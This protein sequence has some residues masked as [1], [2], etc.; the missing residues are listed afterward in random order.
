[1][2]LGAASATIHLNVPALLLDESSTL[3]AAVRHA[4][5]R[6]RFIRTSLRR[7]FDARHAAMPS[8]TREMPQAVAMYDDQAL[9]T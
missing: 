8:A 3:Q 9:G 5:S 4:L 7:M 6:H 1:M 2:F